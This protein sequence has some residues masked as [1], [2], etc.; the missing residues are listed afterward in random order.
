MYFFRIILIVLLILVFSLGVI[1]LINSQVYNISATSLPNKPLKNNLDSSNEVAYQAV[2]KFKVLSRKSEYRIGDLISIDMA[3][4]NK[5]KESVYF[6]DLG[7]KGDI[8]VTDSNDNKIEGGVY[9]RPLVFPKFNLINGGD[10]D[11]E[12]F[13]F[14]IGCKNVG[15]KYYDSYKS[16]D[17]VEEMFDKNFFVSD[18]DGCIKINKSGK[19]EIKAVIS[20]SYAEKDNTKKTAVGKME[21][22]PFEIKIID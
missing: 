17:V 5:S 3:I 20:N 7:M 21:S 12:H 9:M 19:Y 18:G 11:S 13:I 2:A 6:V 22:S 15:K 14:L 16:L 1:F 8:S 10:Y 4:L